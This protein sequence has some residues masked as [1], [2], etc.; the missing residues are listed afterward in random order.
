MGAV[1]P[2]LP[3]TSVSAAKHL[4]NCAPCGENKCHLPLHDEVSSCD[5]CMHTFECSCVDYGMRGVLCSHIH[6]VNILYPKTI[7]DLEG[8]AVLE[9]TRD[10]NIEDKCEDLSNLIQQGKK[11]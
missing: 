3:L 4:R 9:N 6:A 8:D 1:K 2:C 5:A 10:I 7:A 11:L